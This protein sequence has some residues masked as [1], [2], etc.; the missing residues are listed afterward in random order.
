VLGL[1]SNGRITQHLNM[2]HMSVG[3]AYLEENV[4][5]TEIEL[6]KDDLDRIDA[7]VPKDI[8]AGDRYSEGLMK[9][10]DR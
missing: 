9:T 3:R 7:I 10:V 2:P 4:A 5:A 1:R 8:A 6:T